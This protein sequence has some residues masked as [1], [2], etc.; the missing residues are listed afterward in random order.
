MI[1]FIKELEGKE[2]VKEAYLI[3]E[4]A[5]E[6]VHSLIMDIRKSNP[7]YHDKLVDFNRN[8]MEVKRELQHQYDGFIINVS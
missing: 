3:L 5:S 1:D 4:E 2:S 7:E 8:L 6:K